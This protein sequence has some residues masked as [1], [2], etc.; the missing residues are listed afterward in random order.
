[1]QLATRGRYNVNVSK[2]QFL[3]KWISSSEYSLMEQRLLLAMLDCN[4][5]SMLFYFVLTHLLVIIIII[6]ELLTQV[7]TPISRRELRPLPLQRS[8]SPARD[9]ALSATASSSW[10]SSRTSR[11]L[12]R[13]TTCSPAAVWTAPRPPAEACWTC[14][15]ARCRY[16][17]HRDG[18]G[19]YTEGT[20]LEVGVVL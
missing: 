12:P 18:A 14:R 9:R 15:P 8:S 20:V 4:V 3:S 19:A 7:H 11:R 13:P 17:R 2:L 16:G 6:I 10:P 1:M 5:S